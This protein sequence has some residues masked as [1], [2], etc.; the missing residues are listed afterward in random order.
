VSI[1]DF[2]WQAAILILSLVLGDGGLAMM[3][4]TFL[5]GFVSIVSFAACNFRLMSYALK[6][7]LIENKHRRGEMALFVAP[8]AL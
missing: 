5:C 7:V 2:A 6:S 1:H 3:L 8:R 4:G